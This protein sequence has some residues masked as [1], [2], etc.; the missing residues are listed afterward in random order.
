M[1]ASAGSQAILPTKSQTSEFGETKEVFFFSFL[2]FYPT[3][4]T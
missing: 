4:Q 1:Q 2:N 3:E